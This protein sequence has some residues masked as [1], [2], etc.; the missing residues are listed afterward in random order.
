M[1]RCGPVTAAAALVFGLTACSSGAVDLAL[2]EH[3]AE[4]VCG[5]LPWPARTGPARDLQRRP[6]TVDS[7]AVAA[8]GDPAVIARCGLPPLAPTTL[9]CVTVDDVDWVIRPLDDG[10][11]FTTFGTD[12]AI[13]VLIP[14]DYAPETMLLTDFAAAARK[15][16]RTGH[17]CIAPS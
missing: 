15:L 3:A 7:P 17:S 13:E 14:A 10:H 4:S 1:T 6:V 12:P 11:A 5:D 8:W 9:N 16:P 2:P